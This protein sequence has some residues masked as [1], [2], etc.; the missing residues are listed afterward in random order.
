MGPIAETIKA[1]FESENYKYDYV[2]EKHFFKSGFNL[3]NGSVSV[4]LDA[5]E[6]HDYFFCHVAW[7]GNVPTRAVGAVAMVLNNLNY[8]S[9]FTT[10]CVDPED[11]ELVCHTGVNTDGTT[12]SIDQ[13]RLAVD[14][15][16]DMLDKHID[17]IMAAA[18]GTPAGT[19]N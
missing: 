19:N 4:I 16:T 11:G 7:R 13:V 15:C 6:E 9:K 5:N 8:H 18:W 10:L 12:L 2:E 14:M 17:E 1:Y 3:Q